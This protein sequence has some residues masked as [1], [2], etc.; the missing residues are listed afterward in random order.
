MAKTEDEVIAKFTEAGV[1]A[2]RVALDLETTVAT[3]PCTNE[4]VF[5]GWKRH[6]QRVIQCWG[7]V[8]PAKRVI[9]IRQAT[10][11]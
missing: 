6:A 4:Y 11:P 10:A 5:D 1:D 3:P 2:C 9:A 7:A 8:E